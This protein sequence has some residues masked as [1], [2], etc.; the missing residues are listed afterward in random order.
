MVKLSSTIDLVRRRT[1]GCLGADGMEEVFLV[2]SE[3][4]EHGNLVFI[5]KDDKSP[6]EITKISVRYQHLF[7]DHLDSYSLKVL[8]ATNYF[9]KNINTFSIWQ[10]RKEFE[11]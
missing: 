1:N 11:L 5:L 8:P 9:T 2:L 4:K 3:D 7:S 10:C 6:Q